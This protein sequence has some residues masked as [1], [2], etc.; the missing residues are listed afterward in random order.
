MHTARLERTGRERG[1]TLIEL[2]V[3]IAI[4]AL[5]I[6]ILLPALGQA[7]R[8]AQAVIAGSNARQVAVGVTMYSTN[9]KDYF[10]LSYA[11][12]P[13]EESYV[14]R[15]EEQR[16]SHPNP[17]HGYIHWSYALYDNGS[18]PQEAFTSPGTFR[19]GAPRT[20]PGQDASDWEDQQINDVGSSAVDPTVTDR[21]V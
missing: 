19:G 11:Y 4:I 1:F 21:Q 16:Q 14:W 2:L 17:Q 9:N 7:R 12:A 8:S 13:D 18:V 3:V 15:V 20:N 5:L 6:G 10:P